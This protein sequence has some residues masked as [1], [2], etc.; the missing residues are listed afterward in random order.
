MQADRTPHAQIRT[1]H[2][3][4]PSDFKRVTTAPAGKTEW[5]SQNFTNP[6]KRMTMG[7]EEVFGDHDAAKCYSPE[8]IKKRHHTLQQLEVRARR[9]EAGDLGRKRAH[10][11]SKTRFF[12]APDNIDIKADGAISQRFPL[13]HPNI[14]PW[15]HEVDK[16]MRWALNSSK[17]PAQPVGS[18]VVAECANN[19]QP[20]KSACVS[21]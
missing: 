16:P 10:F 2:A 5:S 18:T 1:V 8:F 3:C 4:A 14:V 19:F 12:G 7:T 17:I 20:I 6:L 11:I 21:D 15:R 9:L 13:T